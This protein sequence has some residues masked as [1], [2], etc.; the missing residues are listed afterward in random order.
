MATLKDVAKDAGVS[1][2]TVSCCL[3]GSRYVKPETRTKIMDS[4]EKLKYIPNSSARDLR[5]TT[6]NRIGIVLTDI[7]NTYHTEIFKGISSYLQRHGY[8][9]S[10][11]FSNNL[12][13]IECEKIDDFVSQ[14]VSGLV[15]I[16]CQ[17]QNTDFF[18]NRIKNYNIPTVF[19][20]RRPDNIDVSFAGFDNHKTLY[21]IT[22]ALLEKGYRD[23][24]LF[25]GNKYFSSEK[26]CMNGYETAFRDYGLLPDKDM[27]HETDMSK[28]DAFK[29]AMM[30]LRNR[31]VQAIITTSENIALGVLEIL[32]IFGIKVPDD[33]PFFTLSEESWNISGRHP[34]V[35]HSSRTAFT[36]G[37]E[38]ARLLVEKIQAP[39]FFEEKTILFPDHIPEFKSILPGPAPK[40]SM[41]PAGNEEK[42]LRILMVDL[43]TSRSAQLLST[44]FTRKTGIPVEIE[45]VHQDEILNRIARDIERSENHYD[46]YMY[47]VPWLEYMVQNGYLADITDFVYGDMFDIDQLFPENM[48]NCCFNDSYYG[49]PII[50]GT[51]IM[52]YR[53]DL[54]ENREIAKAFKHKYQISL[55]PPKTWTEFNGIA[56]FFTRK[57]N[58][59]SPTEFGTS[60]AGIIDEELAPEILIRLWASG[61][62][63]WDKSYRACLNTQENVKAFHSI[64]NTM[65]YTE[66]SPF[67][68]SIEQTVKD[69]TSG[70]TAML[71][72]YTEYADQIS[73]HVRTNSLGRV[74]YKALPGKTPMS[75]GWNFGLNPYSPKAKEAY[76]YFQWLCQK[77][78]SYYMTILDGQSPVIA[79]YHSHELLKLYPW[80]ELT[81]ESFD[82]CRKRNG[83]CRTKSLVIPQNKIEAILCSVL[84]DIVKNGSSITDALATGQAEM[85]L[86][87]K[88]YGYPR[89]LHFIKQ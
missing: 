80:L 25:T 19:I 9:I 64:I 36:L 81:E 42:T 21:N 76:Q 45:F 73:K 22:A 47:D 38:A 33:I 48:N 29:T 4:I 40:K 70:K 62:S 32:Y 65:S 20:E 51:Q 35:V 79:P 24:A 84:R 6:T 72:T 30:C 71:V 41:L 63:V 43:A 15:I 88:A 58:P 75:I 3:S 54:F 28:E 83:P 8:T 49:I 37:K 27:I 34:G 68:T 5:S 66:H 23:I 44:Y 12:P 18:F 53:Q 77:E 60:M 74:G 26:D 67:E 85:E 59:D 82:Y 61:G 39:V 11:A 16:T 86:L 57:Y 46:V 2:A 89:P 31:P 7:D 1:I 52:F 78:I 55:R 69:F 14:N 17:P 56:E 10:V 50:G 13:D 87:F